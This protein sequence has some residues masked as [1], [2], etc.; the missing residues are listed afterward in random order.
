MKPIAALT[1]HMALDSLAMRVWDATPLLL[2]GVDARFGQRLGYAKL[3]GDQTGEQSIAE[4]SESL[5]L[6]F[7]GTHGFIKWRNVCC[8]GFGHIISWVQ[9]FDPPHIGLTQLRLDCAR[10]VR[11]NIRALQCKHQMLC[12]YSRLPLNN[13][14]MVIYPELSPNILHDWKA[15]L[16][17]N[18]SVLSCQ[19]K[20]AI[21]KIAINVIHQGRRTVVWIYATTL[22]AFST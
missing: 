7:I 12:R 1:G 10:D 3:A 15:L 16:I 4:D 21:E 14:C 18:R 8:E 11:L 2:Q 19:K 9:K 17:R 6:F 20:D 22:G 13:V 5:D